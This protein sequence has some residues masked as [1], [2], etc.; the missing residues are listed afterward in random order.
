MRNYVFN[1]IHWVMLIHFANISL[2]NIEARNSSVFLFCNLGDWGR[3]A[4]DLVHSSRFGNNEVNFSLGVSFTVIDV[5][6][7]TPL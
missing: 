6:K 7:L 4:V 2:L 1:V 3:Y 5:V